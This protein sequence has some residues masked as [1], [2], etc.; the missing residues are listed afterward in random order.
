[1]ADLGFASGVFLRSV[2]IGI[3]I[4]A[5][6]GP[7]GVL[8][9]R[10]TLAQGMVFG[11][12]TGLGAACADALFA[13]LAGSGLALISSFLAGWQYWIH[14]VGGIFLCF[15]GI[16]TAR[17]IP[18]SITPQANR[19]G[20]AGAFGTTFFLTLTNPITMIS[21]AGIFAG[22]GL[23]TLGRSAASVS[24]MVLG[25]FIGSCLWWLFLSG[26][27][28]LFRA[29]FGARELLWVNRISGCIILAFGVVAIADI[30]L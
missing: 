30:I 18:A 29:R 17:S 23:S 12:A 19:K 7:I 5:P 8:C 10:R 20:L 28:S 3:S 9:V 27:T 6:L 21:F 13:A 15:L 11:L 2:L 1:M 4:A 22:L 25:V 14:L 16:R 24:T 26:A